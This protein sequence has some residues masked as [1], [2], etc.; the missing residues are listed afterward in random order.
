MAVPISSSP[1][2]NAAAKKREIT[3]PDNSD[4][5]EKERAAVARPAATGLDATLSPRSPPPPT[6]A[7]KHR[8]S[9]RGPPPRHPAT[10]RLLPMAGRRK[11]PGTRAPRTAVPG[12][13][14]VLPRIPAASNQRNGS[15]PP[16]P[17]R[18]GE[19]GRRR[20]HQRPPPH[21]AKLRLLEMAVRSKNWESGAPRTAVPECGRCY[22]HFR[23]PRT[24]EAAPAHRRHHHFRQ[25]EGRGSSRSESHGGLCSRRQ[26]ISRRR[27]QQASW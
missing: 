4:K 9:F 21:S 8:S 6:A 18:R 12:M 26:A 2:Q 1:Q 23:L 16:P 20:N 22:L 24:K 14:Q 27:R 13:W 3:G 11:I 19:R 15:R 25:E 17:H 5:P 10:T 7:R